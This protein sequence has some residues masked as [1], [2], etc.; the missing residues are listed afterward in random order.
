MFCGCFS[1]GFYIYFIFGIFGMVYYMYIVVGDS[2]DY[3]LCIG[4]FVMWC[5]NWF[6]KIGNN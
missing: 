5:K 3:C 2:G 6:M 1:N 4:C